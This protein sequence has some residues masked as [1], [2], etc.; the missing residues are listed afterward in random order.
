MLLSCAIMAHRANRFRKLSQHYE[1]FH[2][3]KDELVAEAKSLELSLKLVPYYYER[4]DPTKEVSQ[5][6]LEF[7]K[8]KLKEYLP[9]NE[10]GHDHLHECSQ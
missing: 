10:L 8:T 4:F 1:K 6:S 3:L 5:Q 9:K 2:D 7:I